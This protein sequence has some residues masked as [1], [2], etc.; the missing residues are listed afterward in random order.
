MTYA[1]AQEVRRA[2]QAREAKQQE[3]AD[4]YGT[5]QS[6]ISRIISHDI[7]LPVSHGKKR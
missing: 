1:D 4:R 2:Y 7:W 3:L 5:T 6:I